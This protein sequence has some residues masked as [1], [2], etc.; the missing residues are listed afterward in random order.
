MWLPSWLSER[1]LMR[2]RA[3]PFLSRTNRKTFEV[4]EKDMF[5]ACGRNIDL[6]GRV[7]RLEGS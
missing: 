2:R 3:L 5:L 6:E 4:R 7:G 1:W